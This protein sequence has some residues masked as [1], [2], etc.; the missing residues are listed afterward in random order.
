[1]EMSERKI[2]ARRAGNENG[3]MVSLTM[4][5][6]SVRNRIDFATESYVVSAHQT[7]LASLSRA[8]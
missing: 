8:I 2:I 4:A 3:R 7:T 1:M 6:V 5:D